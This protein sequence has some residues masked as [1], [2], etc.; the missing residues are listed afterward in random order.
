VIRSERYLHNMHTYIKRV[1][2]FCFLAIVAGIFSFYMFVKVSVESARIPSEL[3]SYSVTVLEGETITQVFNNLQNG[4]FI[5]SARMAVWYM[6]FFPSEQG[7]IHAGEYVLSEGYTFGQI[8]DALHNGSFEER[9]T[10]IEGWRREEYARYLSEKVGIDFAREFYEISQGY[11]GKLFPDTYF[12]DESTSAQTLFDLMTQTFEIRYAQAVSEDESSVLLQDE[13]VTIASIV[14]RETPRSDDKPIVAGI[15]LKRFEYGWP[16]GS[17]VTVQYA[18]ATEKSGM[19]SSNDAFLDTDFNWWEA[20]ISY[21]DL[22]IQSDFNTRLFVGLP[23]H[24]IANPGFDSLDAVLHS[25][26]SDYW[27]FIA[28]R[29]GTIRYART[30]D[31]HNYNI[32][33]Y[34]LSE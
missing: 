15:F 29:E 33:T 24:A 11:E 14:E 4:G 26:K 1:S 27:Y 34:G 19:S 28:D 30:I 6:R 7:V 20:E 17:D 32:A 10:F 5:P 3:S 25:E 23:P 9:L 16:L 22:E 12:I 21:N 18:V 13:I 2:V 8:Y 31:E